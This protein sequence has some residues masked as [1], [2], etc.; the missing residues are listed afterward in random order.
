VRTVLEYLSRS[1]KITR[2]VLVCHGETAFRTYE[3]AVRKISPELSDRHGPDAR[4]EEDLKQNNCY[5]ESAFREEIRGQLQM[6][7]TVHGIRITNR[8]LIA[9]EIVTRSGDRRT[10]SRITAALNSWVA[11]RGIRGE[12]EVP[13]RFIAEVIENLSRQ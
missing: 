8:D 13:V 3:N 11:V 1:A 9:D 12:A 7:E 2:V 4:P 10:A 6:I 5:S